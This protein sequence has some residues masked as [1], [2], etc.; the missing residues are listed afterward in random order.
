MIT[1][2]HFGDLHPS[3]RKSQNITSEY[4]NHHF[5]E[6]WPSLRLS[7]TTISA[8]LYHHFSHL[9]LSTRLTM[10]LYLCTMR[11]SLIR[12]S[13]CRKD[14]RRCKSSK[15]DSY[16]RTRGL[17]MRLRD[18]KTWHLVSPEK[19]ER[20]CL[21]HILSINH[22][23]LYYTVLFL[24]TTASL[25]VYILCRPRDHRSGGRGVSRD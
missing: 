10:F 16:R 18:N 23:I 17:M 15:C 20:K 19:R 14:E 4:P 8:I 24:Y 13:G 1:Y 6:H 2:H 25:C 21:V 12:C 22:D 7:L 3:L 5:G 11:M 9:S